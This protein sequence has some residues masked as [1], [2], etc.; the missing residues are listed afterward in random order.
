MKIGN[1]EIGPKFPP[2]IIAEISG[3]HGGSLENAK[4]LIIRAK[5]AGADIVKTQC[6]E[7]RTITLEMNKPDFIVQD[8]LWKGRT[9]WELYKS[10]HTP[11]DWHPDLYRVARDNGITIFSSVFDRSAVDHLERLGCPAYKIASMEITDTV[12]IKHAVDTGK[13]IIISTGMA[14]RQEIIDALAVAPGAAFLHCMSEYPGTI[15]TSNLGKMRELMKMLPANLIGISDHS[16]GSLIPIAAV[17]LGACIIEKHFGK[18]PGVKS[19]DDE[20]SMGVIDFKHMATQ[21]RQTFLAM[22]DTPQDGNPSRQFRRSL[23]AVENIK[24]GEYYTESNIRS[25]RPGYGIPCKFYPTL[26]GKKAHR[27]YRKGDPLV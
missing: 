17:A 7:P 9:L 3:C 24:K 22:Q 11:F 2:L 18:L 8:G 23:Y 15:E 26:L 16:E 25:I 5:Q 21:A 27:D 4:Q 12:L 6:Y 13:P 1:R 19:E 14:S 20:F 10:A